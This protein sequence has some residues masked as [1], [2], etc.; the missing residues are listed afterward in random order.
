MK[1]ID[2][3]DRAFRDWLALDPAGRMRFEDKRSAALAVMNGAEATARDTPAPRKKRT[4][5][6][7]RSVEV[8]DAAH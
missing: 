7:G 6:D 4:P 2:P 3:V 5:K 1:K 8:S